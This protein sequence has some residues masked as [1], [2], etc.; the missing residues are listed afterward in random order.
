MKTFAQSRNHIGARRRSAPRCHADVGL[1]PPHDGQ[2]TAPPAEPGLTRSPGPPRGRHG[3]RADHRHPG[4]IEQVPHRQVRAAS[5]PWSWRPR[6]NH[7]TANRTRPLR[8]RNTAAG[9]GRLTSSSTSGVVLVRRRA[10]A[11]TAARHETRTG[12]ATGMIPALYRLV[13]GGSRS[14]WVVP[15]GLLDRRPA[16]A[17]AALGGWRGWCRRRWVR[18][19]VRRPGRVPRT[20]ARA[21][22]RG[23]AGPGRGAPGLRPGRPSLAG[24]GRY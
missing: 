10:P 17:T 9:T 12:S 13:A 7:S 1:R 15:G 22:S 18:C 4:T 23:V 2:E 11:G 19:Q 8:N 6:R 5:P 14:T 16:R 20:V 3:P 21:T 24:T